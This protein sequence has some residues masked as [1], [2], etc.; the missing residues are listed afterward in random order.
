[1]RSGGEG[2]TENTKRPHVSHAGWA[3]PEVWRTLDPPLPGERGRHPGGGARA[4]A[5]RLG[6]RELL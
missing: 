6:Q 3:V 4:R 5:S 1:M 2:S